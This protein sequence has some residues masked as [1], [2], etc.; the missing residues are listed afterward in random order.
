MK[1]YSKTHQI[2]ILILGV[3][4]LSQINYT[5]ASDLC[6]KDGYT[7]I[8]INGMVTTPPGAIYNSDAV[9]MII[10]PTFNNQKVTVDYVYNATHL[11]GVG[12]FADSATQKVFEGSVGKSYDLINMIDDLSRK[13]KT[14]KL[15]FVAHSQG[16]F[17]ANDIYNSI[18]SKAGGVPADSLSI[19][20]IGSPT[21]YVA[22][23]GKYIT[24]S[25]DKIMNM[26]R[27]WGYLKV[28]PPNVTI[29]GEDGDDPDGHNL[30]TIYLKHQRNRIASEILS[31]LHNLKENDIQ[32]INTICISA[33][34]LTR[35]HKLMGFF[36]FMADPFSVTVKDGVT[37]IFNIGSFVTDKVEKTSTSLGKM[38]NKMLA[39]AG[40]TSSNES[41]LVVVADIETI[42][43]PKIII[44]EIKEVIIVKKE[45]VKNTEIVLA[46][47]ESTELEVVEDLVVENK[48]HHSGRSS[49]NSPF[50]DKIFPIISMKGESYLKITK[51]SIYLDEGATAFDN[52]DGVIAVT[53]DGSVDPATIGTH[54]ITYSA[55]D[56]SNNISTVERTVEVYVPLE[57][58]I[59]STNTTL[60]P[61]EYFYDNL[62]IT[63]NATLTLSANP[64]ST[65]SFKGVIINAKNI[66]VDSGSIISADSQGY[67]NGP[68][69]LKEKTAGGSYGGL[70]ERNSA[71]SIYGSAT[72]PTDLGSGGSGPYGHGGGAIKLV[73]S[74]II[75]N[76]GII[77]ANGHTNSS[78][79][80]IYVIAGEVS[81]VGKFS[82]NGGSL[83]LTTVI[84][85]N[86]GG[87]RIA[88]YYDTNTFTGTAEALGGCG[89]YDGMTVVCAEKGTVGFFDNINNDLLIN[90]SWYFI[91][92]DSP[93]NFNKISII[94]GAKVRTE[95]G[96]NITVGDFEIKEKSTLTLSG[97]E[98]ISA[99]NFN[100][101][102]VSIL[103]VLPEKTLY[104]DVGNINIE[105]NSSVI[106]DGKGY[107][108]GP[109]TPDLDYK[110]GAS[111][112]GKGGGDIAKPAYGSALTPTDFGSGQEMHRGGGAIHM[113]AS[114]ELK[115]DGIVSANGVMYRTSGGSIYIETDIISGTGTFNA[116]GS[117]SQYPYGPVGGGGGRIAI[118]YNSLLFTGIKTVDPGKY[119][120]YGCA[121]AG[122]VGT[123]K[124]IDRSVYIPSSEKKISSFVFTNLVPEVSGTIDEP[125]HSVLASVPFGTSIIDL[126]PAILISTKS[127]ID[128]ASGTVQ[129][130][131]SPVLYT[132]TAEDGSS[133]IYTVTVTVLPPPDTTAPTIESYTLNGFPESLTINPLTVPIVANFTS[134]ENVIWTSIKIENEV[135]SSLY[136]IFYSKV[137]CEDNT[138]ACTKTWDGLLSGTGTVITNGVYKI[139][140][141]IKDL[142]GN[143]YYDYLPSV[144]NVIENPI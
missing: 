95:S 91:E 139:K 128:K 135:D 57:G 72:E 81:G 49:D 78:G 17:Y 55:K 96:V 77:R 117:P 84:N 33:P 130:F 140:V 68:G 141:H 40:N 92:N 28:L 47:E 89:R 30:S 9:D 118:Y 16:N 29:V 142:A 83:Q 58:L 52:I 124:M 70:G 107:I 53:V 99:D 102:G 125:N 76:N 132:V 39:S 87:G 14:Q 109:G 93:F 133:Q 144:I 106:A 110:A 36:Y 67:V 115:N 101:S 71:S 114:G 7:V 37:G 64:L 44:P 3:F 103:T 10:D 13:V 143:E 122:E 112:G 32:N 90:S 20:G 34:E 56:S 12:D 134:S 79:G 137:D 2:L 119:C 111:Y 1:N 129:D 80:S 82:A 23:G 19:Y 97:E 108:I 74:G 126:V 11:E 116:N 113:I 60:L 120:L 100:I 42:D 4:F 18:S 26:V 62:T 38:F 123:I 22:G 85:G 43:T 88:I 8:T 48:S 131:T 45:E 104:L 46:K 86:G 41:P 27:M 69:T 24:S 5:E 15:L 98:V 94:G 73:V 59:I 75:S 50:T 65:D 31:S 121:L 35:L 54:I 6:S 136:R 25:N 51:D 138:N 105:K 61:G 66:T 63:N 127:S 21:S